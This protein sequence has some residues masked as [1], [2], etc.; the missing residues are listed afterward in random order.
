MPVSAGM[1]ESGPL[2]QGEGIKQIAFT[3]FSNFGAAAGMM[4]T[5]D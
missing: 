2:G 3:I 4:E 5:R 1:H